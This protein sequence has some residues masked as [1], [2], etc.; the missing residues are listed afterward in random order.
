[1]D[2]VFLSYK[3]EERDRVEEI[4]D[5]LRAEGLTVFFDPDLLVGRVWDEQLEQR[6]EIAK[7][8]AVLWSEKARRSA[9][10]RSEARRAQGMNKLVPARLDGCIVPIG[11]DGVQEA[12]LRNWRSGNFHHV[13]WRKFV[14]G[15]TAVIGGGEIGPKQP[16]LPFLSGRARVS[17]IEE[18]RFDASGLAAAADVAGYRHAAARGEPW[19]AYMM[20][21]I[22]LLGFAG[23]KDETEALA[24]F[25]AAAAKNWPGAFYAMGVMYECGV[26]VRPSTKKAVTNYRRAARA[27]HAKAAANLVCLEQQGS[28][29]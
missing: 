2:D 13:E 11:L 19:A 20:G 1:M 15:I 24:Y 5:G 16:S 22:M 25:R 14:G 17:A 28:A 6:L 23:P 27:G 7:S 3:R 21:V 4:A 9:W 8:V 26:G 18:L 10:V 12:D 29:A